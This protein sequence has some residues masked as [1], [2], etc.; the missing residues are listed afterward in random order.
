MEGRIHGVSIC[1]RAP[2]ISHLLFVDESLMFC[3]AT[4]R[5]VMEI[6]KILQLYARAFGQCINME[7]SSILFNGNTSDRQKDLTKA[8][9]GV[10]EVVRFESYL[11]LPTMV[12]RAKYQTF[13][14]LKD[15][16]WK[17][18]QGWKGKLLSRARKE[19]LIKAMAQS[20]ST[21]TMGVFQFSLRL[22]DELNSLCARF[23][24]GQLGNE[25]KIH[26]KSRSSL[27]HGFSGSKDLQPGYVGK[28]KDGN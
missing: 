28:A 25:R 5:E 18:L 15:R 9:L 22:C 1:R 17:K 6:N 21:Y 12:G 3:L 20:I 27:T 2:K 8:I 7:K 14:Y 13:T 4:H 23:W 26:W 24:W 19:V 10:K 11:G 16:V